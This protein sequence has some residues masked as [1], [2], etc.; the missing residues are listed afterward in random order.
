MIMVTGLKNGEDNN[1]GRKDNLPTKILMGDSKHALRAASAL[2]I[3]V[4]MLVEWKAMLAVC[5]SNNL[6]PV[7][8]V[9]TELEML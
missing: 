4:A 3:V 5:K 1:V 6:F 2:I 8:I 9:P 7:A